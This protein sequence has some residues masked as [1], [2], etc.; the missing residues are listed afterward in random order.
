MLP[1][2]PEVVFIN[3]PS[4]FLGE[5]LVQSYSFRVLLFRHAIRVWDAVTGLADPKLVQVAICPSHSAIQNLVENMETDIPF[6]SNAP[7]DQRLDSP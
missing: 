4:F 1:A 2:I 6:H 3:E 7:P 5:Q